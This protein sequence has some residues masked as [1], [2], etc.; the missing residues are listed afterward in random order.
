MSLSHPTLTIVLATERGNGLDPI[1]VQRPLAALPFGGNYRVIDF[2]LT[3]CLHSG[4][5]QVMVLTQYKSQSLH[6]HLRNGWSVFNPEIG[7]YITSVPP[8]MRTGEGWY[9]GSADAI[10]QNRFLLD[11]SAATNVLVASGDRVY[12]MD[13]AALLDFH[14]QH[15]AAVTIGCAQV[16]AADAARYCTIE[17][18][19][20]ERVVA[21]H[22]ATTREPGQTARALACMSVYAFTMPTL[23]AAL[24]SDHRNI[25]SLHDIDQDVVAR[26]VADGGVY[27]YRFGGKTGRVS[28]DRYFGDLGGLD[29]YFR[30]NL[31]LLEPVPPLDLYQSD[32][33]IRSYTGQG[34]PARTVASPTGNEGIFVNSIVAAGVVISGGAVAHSIL[35]PNVRVDDHATVERAILFDDVHVGAGAELRN[36]IV[37][38]GVHIPPGVRIGFDKQGDR[39]HFTVSDGGVVVVPQGWQPG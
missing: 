13:Y 10:W 12:R 26:L 21:F 3:N 5:R 6:E 32:W 16:G 37:D 33:P 19:A 11:R 24:E 15:G 1:T 30:A 31:E 23:L 27:A 8:Q 39:Q 7:E 9:Q 36:C 34:P 29:A 4:L 14:T 28:Q 20:E 18:A 25:E 38:K 22:P 17:T 2:V 35:F